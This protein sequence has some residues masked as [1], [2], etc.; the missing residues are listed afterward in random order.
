MPDDILTADRAAATAASTLDT[1]TADDARA[2]RAGN[3][4]ETRDAYENN[5]LFKRL[6]RQMGQA[7][8]DFNMIE[9][10]DKVMVCLS[11]GKDSYAML[12]IL[13]RLRERAPI[14]FDIIAVNLDQKQPGFPA[15]ILPEYLEK[16]GVPYH[17]E[18]QDTYSI[19]KRLV[20]EGKTTCS[21]CSRLRR[22]VLYRVAGELGATKI[23]LGHHRDDI[24]QTMFLNMFYGGK[25]KGMPPKLQSD[26]G[27]N[28]VIRPLAYVKEVD[29][30]AYAELREFPIIP[31]N[32]CG[33][34]PN[35]KRA[36]MKALIRDWE[37]RFPGRVDNMFNAMQSVVPSHLM[38]RDLFNF[39]GLK[40]TGAPDASGDIAFDEDPC[41]TDVSAGGA[42]G[43]SGEAGQLGDGSQVIRFGGL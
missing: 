3:R 38:D 26:D 6:A 43:A 28:I 20:P 31:C 1:S 23:A 30:E 24:L 14:H 25:L 21:L 9:D 4:R 40:A 29:L 5:K 13:L 39:T 16:R 10:G 32:L 8:G 27:K 18:T 33:S 15:H 35:L 22:G 34:Q 7:I 17:I 19:V 37:K 41:G 36:E 11:G 2:L 42:G 12:D